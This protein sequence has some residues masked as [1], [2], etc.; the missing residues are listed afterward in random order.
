MHPDGRPPGTGPHHIQ[1]DQWIGCAPFEK[2][3]HI[4]IIEAVDGRAI[5]RMPFLI[6]FAQGAGLMHG[7]ALVGLADTAVVMAIKSIVRPQTHFATVTMA[8]E[9]LRPVREGV[10]TARSQLT[11]LKGRELQ[12][13]TRVYDDQ[14]RPVLDFR[15]HFRI[16][17]DARIRNIVFADVTNSIRA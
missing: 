14:E 4:D 17:R 10:V 2:L 5:L 15:A 12:G 13:Q 1:M 16:A 8:T 7:G 9:Y 3:L 11:A 6:D